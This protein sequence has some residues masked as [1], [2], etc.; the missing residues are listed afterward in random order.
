MQTNNTNTYAKVLKH[1]IENSLGLP[2]TMDKLL[3]TNKLA[4]YLD[5]T[6]AT[7]RR[8]ALNGEIPSIKVGNR[9]RFNK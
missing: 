4:E 5:V 8:K 6:P 3:S 7:V 1:I 2:T 9:L